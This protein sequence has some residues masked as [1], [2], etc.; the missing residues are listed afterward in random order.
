MARTKTDAQNVKA[1]RAP[2]LRE[3]LE[4]IKQEL[5][6]DTL[7]LEHK[8]VRVGGFFGIGA[9]DMIEVTVIAEERP[10]PASQ[11]SSTTNKLDISDG[12]A[13][14]PNYQ[15]AGANRKPL[16]SSYPATTPSTS[17]NPTSSTS[18]NNDES[19]RVKT[20][21]LAPPSSNDENSRIKATNLATLA[22]S[23]GAS[24]PAAPTP[25]I[26]SEIQKLRSELREIKFSLASLGRTNSPSDLIPFDMEVYESLYYD[27]YQ[28]LS[29]IGLSA[30]LAHQTIELARPYTDGQSSIMEIMQTG[31][32]Q[33]L[34]TRIHFAEDPLAL[35][36][37]AMSAPG[38]IVFI[39]PTGVGKTTTIAKLAA[40]ANICTRQR[41]ELISLDTYRIAAMEQLRIYAEIIG[42]GFHQ[43]RSTKELQDV[44][45]RFAGK[46]TILIDTAGRN[47][48]DLSDQLELAS[49]LRNSYDILKCL[50]LQATTNP[51]DAQIAIKK[52][53]LYGPDQLVLTKLDETVRPGAITNVIAQS[54]L[55][56]AYLCM[57]QR[58]PED[59]EQANPTALAARMLRAS[60]M[61]MAA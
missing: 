46:A 31:L 10:T 16:T 48:N 40:Q 41:V 7:V 38:A 20:S 45:Q 24:S 52:F 3:A 28:E 51:T 58:I 27:A 60:L 47:P 56:L 9:K 32:T 1:Y 18:S 33:M 11:T 49:Y 4:Q 36:A 12:D 37:E 44:V 8:K 54:G 35:K 19:S 25:S 14:L 5:G 43:V 42:V 2:T 57:G 13:I 59:L 39:G 23:L 29:E 15:E 17:A 55:P 50:V 53:S 34:N 30:E 26:A 22:N 6:E 61:A 21:N